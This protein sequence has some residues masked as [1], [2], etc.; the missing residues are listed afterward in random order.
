MG[1]AG[2]RYGTRFEPENVT[3]GAML[4]VC[5]GMLVLV[6]KWVGSGRQCHTPASVGVWHPSGN[7]PA[8]SDWAPAA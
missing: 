1:V 6:W 7:A 2:F 3:R 8:Q 5:V 4:H